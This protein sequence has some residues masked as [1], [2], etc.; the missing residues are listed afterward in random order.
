MRTCSALTF[1][2][3]HHVPPEYLHPDKQGQK[4]QLSLATLDSS[5]YVSW[6]CHMPT[7]SSS[8]PTCDVD[9]D[10]GDLGY[11]TGFHFACVVAV[12]FHHGHHWV[13]SLTAMITVCHNHLVLL[14][15]DF[16]KLG[17][18]PHLNGAHNAEL[19]SFCDLSLGAHIEFGHREG[20]YKKRTSQL[21]SALNMGGGKRYFLSSSALFMANHCFS[22]LIKKKIQP[23][24][25]KTFTLA[26]LMLP[27]FS[28][29]LA[30][31]VFL[32][33]IL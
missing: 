18:V 6:A 9:H 8:S 22:L 10:A 27:P 21:D 19:F 7:A 32:P 11:P 16:W 3:E 17:Q 4:E 1:P 31:S 2:H 13:D 28:L 23:F 25:S 12:V 14:D 20:F 5:T 30:S 15:Y 33:A 26:A 24:L 29:T